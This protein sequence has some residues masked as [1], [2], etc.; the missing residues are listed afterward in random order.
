MTDTVVA[1]M[2]ESES[3]THT[4]MIHYLISD[5]PHPEAVVS[6]DDFGTKKYSNCF[7]TKH[8]MG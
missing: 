4:P 5:A 3:H 7:S 6:L 2:R 1:E 8:L